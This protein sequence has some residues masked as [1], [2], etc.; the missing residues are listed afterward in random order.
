MRVTL[1]G[2]ALL[3]EPE[4]EFETLWIDNHFECRE[5]IKCYVKT[6]L[7]PAERVGIKVEAN[8]E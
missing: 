7:T 2:N 3:I 8:R 4:T 5:S 6:G 1:N